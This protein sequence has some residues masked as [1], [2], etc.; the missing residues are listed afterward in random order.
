MS[1]LEWKNSSISCNIGIKK[2]IGEMQNFRAKL[3]E[4]VWFPGKIFKF[5]KKYEFNIKHF[6][7]CF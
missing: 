1:N 2:G 3:H 6:T 4:K 5:T 7:L